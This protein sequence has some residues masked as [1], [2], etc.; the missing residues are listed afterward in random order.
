VGPQTRNISSPSLDKDVRLS[1]R[2]QGVNVAGARDGSWSHLCFT[3]LY[4]TAKP[5]YVGA[6]V[7]GLAC[8]LHRSIVCV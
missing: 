7:D 2:L 1:F 3:W 5:S 4:L 8:F 6:D